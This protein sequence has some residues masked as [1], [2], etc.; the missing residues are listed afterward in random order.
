MLTNKFLAGVVISASLFSII[1]PAM[2]QDYPTRPIRL[3]IPYGQGGATDTI[4]RMFSGPMEAELGVPVVVTNQP[5]A[6]GA[7]G[8]A[9]AL[10]SSP[11]GYT[12]AIGSDSSLS[13]RPLMTDSGYDINSIQPI[14]RA[15]QAPMTFVVRE[16]SEVGNLDGLLAEMADGNLTWSSPGVGSGPH[17][18]A[19]SFFARN[20]VTAQH[21]TAAS[22]GE[23]MV[24]LLAGEVEMISV[25]GSNVAGLLGDPETPIRVLGVANEGRW[26]RMPESPTFAEQDYDYTRPVW[27]GF[28]APKGTPDAIVEKL[29]I[30]VEKILTAD[31]SAKLLESFHLSPAFQTPEAFGEQIEAETKEFGDVLAGIG[32]ARGQ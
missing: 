25:V 10:S 12:I 31:E 9:T 5:G 3:I 2:A 19:E 29:A 14:A 20:E 21:V 23:A 22:A 27:F 11:D 32:M 16:D 28:V 30:T 26:E 1:L 6:G 4:G 13:A 17:L 8:L 24:K 15:V 7:V 18:G